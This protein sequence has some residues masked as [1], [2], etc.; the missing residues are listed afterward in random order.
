[1][2]FC[3]VW[4]VFG[5]ILQGIWI[6]CVVGGRESFFD[7]NVDFTVLLGNGRMILFVVW[8]MAVVC[9]I[10]KLMVLEKNM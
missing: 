6:D 9:C 4:I 10:K 1:M 7:C 3:C 5:E 8:D 2:F